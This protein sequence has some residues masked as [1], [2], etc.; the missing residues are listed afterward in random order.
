MDPTQPPQQPKPE[1]FYCAHFTERA[2]GCHALHLG[3]GKVCSVCDICWSS[4]KG[5][6]LEE[7]VERAARDVLKGANWRA[8]I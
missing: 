4:I 2:H 5:R 8:D 3:A 6:V 7:V 1:A